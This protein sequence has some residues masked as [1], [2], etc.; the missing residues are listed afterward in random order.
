MVDSRAHHKALKDVLITAG[1]QVEFAAPNTSLSSILA[2]DIPEAVL[3]PWGQGKAL[4]Q[5]ACMTIR[6]ACPNVPMII[7]GP[8]TY[9]KAKVRLFDL[10]ADDYVEE[11][12]DDAELIARLRST[13][14]RSKART[15]RVNE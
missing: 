4:P 3:V 11:P 15:Q 13:I 10:G 12:F 1:Y 2:S 14:R 9:T 6:R 8:K 7:L 5:A